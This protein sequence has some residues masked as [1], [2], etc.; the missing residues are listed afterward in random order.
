[1]LQIS[2]VREA[3]TP[4]N[5]S[6]ATTTN[7]DTATTYDAAGFSLKAINVRAAQEATA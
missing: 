4:P 6:Q 2:D 3:E 7:S 5:I 1:M